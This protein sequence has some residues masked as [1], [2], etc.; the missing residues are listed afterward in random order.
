MGALVS[1]RLSEYLKRAFPWIT[2]DHISW[3][4]SQISLHWIKGDSLRWKEFVRNRVREIQEKTNRG[5]WNYCRGKTNPADKLTRGL[6][7]IQVLA[8]DDVWWNGPDWLFNP[9]L[10]LD[11]TVNSEFNEVE[12]ANELKKDYVPAS[13]LL[14]AGTLSQGL[15]GP[16][17]LMKG[18]RQKT[19]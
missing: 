12:V 19:N 5:Q 18:L 10:C 2:S 9:D 3:S 4:D 7:I 17:R 11:N 13:N 1:A 14:I 16:L 6:S 15:L 8:Q